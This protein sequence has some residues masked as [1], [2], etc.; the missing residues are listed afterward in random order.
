MC[1]NELRLSS[2]AN[3]FRLMQHASPNSKARAMVYV[4]ATAV[5][6]A[7]GQARARPGLLQI[8]ARGHPV[9][10]EHRALLRPKAAVVFQKSPL[11][12]SPSSLHSRSTLTHV[13]RISLSRSL[14]DYLHSLICLTAILVQASTA[15][16]TL[17]PHRFRST[18]RPSA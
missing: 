5:V 16:L 7:L 18:T 1:V 10:N 14:S 15:A 9:G 12:I 2:C 8:G 11:C 3:A 6:K 13:D 17:S 4:P